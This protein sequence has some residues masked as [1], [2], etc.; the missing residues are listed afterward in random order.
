[1]RGLLGRRSSL[2]GLMW[3]VVR[4]HHAAEDLFQDLVVK[5]LGRRE[6]FDDEEYLTAWARVAARNAALDVVRKEKRRRNLLDGAALE[7]LSED[8][9]TDTGD[10][11]EALR[12]CLGRLPERTREI[13]EDRYG[14]GLTAVEVAG[15]LG[16]KVD[17]VYQTLS[18]AHRSLRECIE[19]RLGTA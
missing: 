14:Q 8:G 13:L 3:A 12:A 17:S 5:A 18:R 15:R 6:Q 4:D 10:R 11:G 16:K 2:C 1:M 9:P 19:R 7:A